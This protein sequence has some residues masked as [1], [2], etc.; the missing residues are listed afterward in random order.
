MEK[1][2]KLMPQRMAGREGVMLCRHMGLGL[3]LSA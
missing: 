3:I 1:P 2:L